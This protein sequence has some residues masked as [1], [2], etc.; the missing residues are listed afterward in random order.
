MQFKEL[1]GRDETK[2]T[3]V[4]LEKTKKLPHAFLI[5]AKEGMGGLPFSLALAQYLQCENKTNDDSCGVCHSC[6]GAQKL[7]HPDI[8]FVFPVFNKDANKKYTSAD[9]IIPFR[10]FVEE[11]PYGN[12]RD[13]LDLA[14]DENKKP[15]ISSQ[16]AHDLIKKLYLTSLTNSYKV[17]IIWLP[18]YLGKEG[19]VLLK[20]IEEP[21]KNTVMIFVAEQQDHLLMT[22]QSRLQ[23]FVLKPFTKIEI[24]NGLEKMNIDE[25]QQ[26]LIS[27]IAEGNWR[28]ALQ[29]LSSSNN[30][31]LVIFKNLL[32]AI[33]TQN[34]ILLGKWL[35]EM[36]DLNKES[37]K[38]FLLYFQQ[39]MELA[40][41]RMNNFSLVDSLLKDEIDIVEKLISKKLNAKKVELI[42][43]KIND[44]L[45]AIERNANMKILL[46]SFSLHC[47]DALLAK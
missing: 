31:E 19:N 34:G 9:F 39:I 35:K 17:A 22:I 16:E 7:Q 12:I 3:F 28:K 38:Q 24:K 32:N 13:W 37:V 15:N 42:N 20:L 47:Q 44:S 36:N 23:L 21:P 10:K 5:L 45:Y 2:E 30:N 11:Q 26:I 29:F 46:H 1:I 40:L 18:E 43:E 6:V 4:R 33:F 27:R 14:G 8:H 25:N 41:R